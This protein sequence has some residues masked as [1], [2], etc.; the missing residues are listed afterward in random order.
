MM[1]TPEFIEL[2][3]IAIAGPLLLGFGWTTRH[4]RFGRGLLVLT[5]AL[6]AATCTFEVMRLLALEKIGRAE[7]HSFRTSS[8]GRHAL[9]LNPSWQ[10]ELPRAGVILETNEGSDRTFSS[11]DIQKATFRLN[12]RE[13]SSNNPT[14]VKADVHR[15]VKLVGLSEPLILEYEVTEETRPFLDACR[16]RVHPA[17]MLKGFGRGRSRSVQ[18]HWFGAGLGFL[19]CIIGMGLAFRAVRVIPA[20]QEGQSGGNS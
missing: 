5:P 4:Q 10:D 13:V 1:G 17:G 9:R 2:V 12:G 15:L 3:A 19:W 7:F 18:F 8:E 16:I 6:F 14:H 11:A 20:S